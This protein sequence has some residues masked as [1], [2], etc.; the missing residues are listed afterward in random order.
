MQPK[1]IDLVL[2]D[3]AGLSNDR[4][5]QAASRPLLVLPSRQIELRR[6]SRVGGTVV[7]VLRFQVEGERN[8]G[9]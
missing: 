2:K 6:D 5:K 8:I 9:G 4:Y 1:W 3:I 7:V